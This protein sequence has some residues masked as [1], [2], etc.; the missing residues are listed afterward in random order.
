MTGPLSTTTPLPPSLWTATAGPL[1][2]YAPLNGDTAT[3]IAILG[4][5]YSGLHAALALAERGRDCLVLEARQPGWGASGRNGGQVIPGVHPAPRTLKRRYGDDRAE[6]WLRESARSADIL[7]EAIAAHNLEC[8]AQESGYLV[9]AHTDSALQRLAARAEAMRPY[10]E[11]SR[12]LSAGET[13]ELSGTSAYI[14]ARLIARGGHLHPVKLAAELARAASHLGARIH[15]ESAAT[16]IEHSDGSW[17]IE[18]ARGTVTAGGLIVATNA[19]TNTLFPD[20][21]R[22]LV[23]VCSL[24][25]ATAPLGGRAKEV[26]PG[27]QAA[28]DTRRLLHYFRLSPDGCLV[29]GSRGPFTT[30]IAMADT[31]RLRRGVA[32]IFP[33]LA[34]EPFQMCWAGWV[35]MTLSDHPSLARIGPRGCALYGYNASGVAISAVLGRAAARLAEGAQDGDIAVPVE[36]IKP[37][38][39]HRFSRI[40]A[41]AAIAAFGLLDRLNL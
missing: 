29:M 34:D 24:Q 26:L 3:D 22:S 38:P 12:M 16:N 6:R 28:S 31:G 13:A 27:G 14:G 17:R 9:L 39:L 32:K 30:D 23:R 15:G 21:D 4:G 36:P 5:G 40:G 20:I 10:G 41:R 37:M 18:T 1:A 33:Q 8:D 19:Y 35:G 11:A 25:A 2:T 7:F